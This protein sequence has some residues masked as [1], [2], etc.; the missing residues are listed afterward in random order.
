MR[1]DI[2]CRVVDNLGDI[3]VSWR[4][5]RQLAVEHGWGV[6]LWLDDL[7][8][9]RLLC[10]A[11]ES[12]GVTVLKLDEAAV[13]PEPAEVVIE[14]FGCG[15]PQR[16]VDAMAAR[17]KKPLWIVLEYLS[18]EP[19]VSG[20]HGLPSPHP[21]HDIPRYFFFPGFA[22]GTGG[23]LCESDLLARRDAFDVHSWWRKLGMT[24]PP[25]DT[26]TVSLFAYAH[27]PYAAWLEACSR[28][29]H[30][31]LVLLP[32]G[33]LAREVRA[34]W[35]HG[36]GAL[37]LR[38]IPFAP[39]AQYDN[40]LWACGV[41]F[42]RGEDSFVRAQW[43]GKPFVWHIYPQAQQAHA[44]KLDAFLHQYAAHTAQAVFWRAWNGVPGAPALDTAWHAFVTAL[45][46]LRKAANAWPDRL[47]MHGELA[48]NL[49]NFCKK[50]L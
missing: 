3:G 34:R 25:P 15:L 38:Y 35:A 42:V 47:A 16:Y 19:W 10:A 7:A 39:Q 21:R 27:A 18:A 23:V 5:A 4:L 8:S 12:S 48:G 46:E 2:F 6:R 24:P 11:P 17:Y 40:L 13:F 33:E 36:E 22:A 26:L 32:D 44:T 37:E 31:T 20:C 41:N 1:C 45:P 30:K 43:A 28:G 49:V 50:R 14:P 9:L 29:E